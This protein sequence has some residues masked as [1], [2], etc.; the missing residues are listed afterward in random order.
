MN[1]EFWDVP[2]TGIGFVLG[3]VM[4]LFFVG[5]SMIV[6]LRPALYA[7]PPGG[8]PTHGTTAAW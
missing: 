3:V 7:H 4:V 8:M 6:G 2:T 1:D 5:L